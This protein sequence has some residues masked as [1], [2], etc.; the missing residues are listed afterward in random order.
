M[1]RLRD[2][3]G[4][5]PGA[6]LHG[7]PIKGWQTITEGA[8]ITPS[9]KVRARRARHKGSVRAA[10]RI[11]AALQRKAEGESGTLEAADLHPEQRLSHH[12]M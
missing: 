7:R 12:G 10:Q 11:A 1:H 5:P 2:H 3:V 9:G 8:C 6:L 4:C